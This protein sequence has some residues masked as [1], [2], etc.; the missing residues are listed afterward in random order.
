MGNEGFTWYPNKPGKASTGGKN[1]PGESLYD[2]LS[3]SYSCVAD[4]NDTLIS[5]AQSLL[6]F[7]GIVDTILV[8]L[9]VVLLT[10]PI[11]EATFQKS[12]YYQLLR[13]LFI[14][15]FLAYIFSIISALIANLTTK[16]IPVPQVP[17]G[18][19]VKDVFDGDRSFNLK[20]YALQA[21]Y[22]VNHYNS[23]NSEKYLWLQLA[24]VLLFFAILITA[25]AGVI[26]TYTMI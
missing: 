13:G 12:T 16:Y 9:I 17:G 2:L 14:V 10:N 21:A 18:D 8:A 1:E 3:D 26:M 23:G 4:R 19:Y 22:A 6:G 5:Q 24:T 11:V 15:G 20:F 7:A 25:I